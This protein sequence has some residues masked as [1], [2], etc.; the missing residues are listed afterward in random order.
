MSI[1]NDFFNSQ[2][3]KQNIDEVFS[4][5]DPLE[6]LSIK[7]YLLVNSESSNES[8]TLFNINEMIRDYYTN[9]PLSYDELLVNYS[10]NLIEYIGKNGANKWSDIYETFYSQIKNLTT[11]EQKQFVTEVTPVA[12]VI[13]GNPEAKDFYEKYLYRMSGYEPYLSLSKDQIIQILTSEKEIFN[14][15]MAIPDGGN[16]DIDLNTFIFESP[17][18]LAQFIVENLPTDDEELDLM[19]NILRSKINESSF[20]QED[21]FISLGE[22][23]SKF[24]IEKK[25]DLFIKT[26]EVIFELSQKGGPA[27]LLGETLE[28]MG[29]LEKSLVYFIKSA[30]I[31]KERLGQN[32]ELTVFSV[33]KAIKV[34]EDLGRFDFN[35]PPWFEDAGDIIDF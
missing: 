10:K 27:F 26:G 24:E 1:I 29:E 22:C 23:A 25:M 34:N 31:R 11:E 16:E 18:E 17:D 5:N 33:Q 21:L 4:T 28:E 20:T 3:N 19:L 32:H 7:F 30:E 14:K 6:I 15:A 9:C 12:F 35:L 8:E 2:E 13:Q